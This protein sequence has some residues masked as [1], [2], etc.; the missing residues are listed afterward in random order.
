MRC[1]QTITVLIVD[2]QPIVRWGLRHF[3]ETQQIRIVSDVESLSEALDKLQEDEPDVIILDTSLPDTDTISAT[4]ELTKD[5]PRRILAFSSKESWEYVEKFINAGGLGFV[6]KRCPPDELITAIRAVANN[7]PWISPAMRKIASG[8]KNKTELNLSP[9][10]REV[11]A[12]IAHGYTSR[13][14]ADQLCVSI[15]T[16]E[17]HRYRIFKHLNIKSRAEL[18]NFA[19]QNG[20]LNN[21]NRL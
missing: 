5:K 15:K 3:L 12:L 11:V 19:I 17:T 21:T 7:Q 18:V 8:N 16:I 13:Q 1:N 9:R 2:E 10:E 20:L 6:S 14:I 4:K